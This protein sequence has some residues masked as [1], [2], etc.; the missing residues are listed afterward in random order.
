MRA[1]GQR[2]GVSALLGWAVGARHFA[3]EI[4]TDRGRLSAAQTAWMDRMALL[5][6]RVHVC[7]S[8]EGLQAIL[9]AEDR[10]AIGGQYTTGN[11]YRGGKGEKTMAETVERIV[12]TMK[13]QRHLRIVSGGTT[14][15][16]PPARMADP[17][18]HV[19]RTEEKAQVREICAGIRARLDA[20]PFKA[21][22]SPE[23]DAPDKGPVG[24]QALRDAK[25]RKDPDFAYTLEKGRRFGMAVDA[26]GA[27]N[28]AK[29]L[30]PMVSPW[31]AICGPPTGIS[32]PG[33]SWQT[34]R[35]DF[36]T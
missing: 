8:L 30:V 36:I 7:R 25:A 1:G 24:A 31:L 32:A 26:G 16:P 9:V 20:V 10:K 3:V 27:L 17:E 2:A 18:K 34:I 12:I 6:F 11:R 15:R 23:A 33:R 14:P 21:S 29:F 13:A 5:G 22:L 35:S 19:P 28:I 4:K